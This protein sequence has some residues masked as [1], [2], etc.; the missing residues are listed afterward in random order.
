MA[1]SEKKQYSEMMSR[2][3]EKKRQYPDTIMFYRLGDF[4]EMFFDDAVKASEILG[5]TLT[6][7]DSGNKQKA[8]MCGIPYHAA[9]TYITRLTAAGYK[10]AIC[11]QIGPII[12][13]KIV[14]RDVVRIVTPG[15][16]MDES[17]LEQR[18]NNFI[19][20]VSAERESVVGL[21]W[22]DLTTGE[23]YLQQ[24]TGDDAFSRL[25]DMLV[26]I[27]PSEIIADELSFNESSKLACERM[28]VVPCFYQHKQSAFD[29][30][31]A[32][33][34]VL[35]QLKVHDLKEIN[36]ENI[37]QAVC[38]GGALLNYL[39]ETQMRDLTHINKVKVI[40]DKQY[41]HLDIN[42][43]LNL[44]LCE[45]LY[46]RKKKGS[47]L[48]VIDKTKSTMGARLLRSWLEQP[49]QDDI[50]IN[51]RLDA[52][53][54]L[55]NN[56]IARCELAE[57][58]RNF[59]DIERL[60]GRVSYGNLNP[61]NCVSLGQALV[62]L[63]R[64]KKLLNQFNSK[65][66]KECASKIA[67][68]ESL[69]KELVT[70]F[71]DNPPAILKDGGFI[72]KGFNPELDVYLSA[73]ENGN[74]WALDLEKKE[75][76][77][78]GESRLKVVHNRVIG[79]CFEI[80]KSGAENLPFRF[81]KIQTLTNVV[82]FMTNDLRKIIE[83]INN[84]EENKLNCELQIFNQIRQHILDKTR[85]IQVSA[86]QVARIDCLL[87]LA[88]V[89]LENDYHK[90]IIN[91]DIKDYEILQS[92]HPVVEK[93]MLNERFVPNDVI[94]N[95]NQRTI[96]ITGPNM[97]GK[98]T[99]MRQIALVVLLAHIGS[100]VPAQSAKIAMT[101]RIFTRIG[102][103]DNLGMGQSTFMVEMTEVANI[104]KNATSNSLLILD[105]IGRGTSTQDGLSIAW[106]VLEYIATTIK[107]RTLF[108]T[109]YHKLTEL[110]GKLPGVVNM[111]V[112]V[113]EFDNQ[114]SF[115]RKVEY[116]STNQSFGV[117]VAKLA[118]IPQSIINRAKE[119]M[120]DEELVQDKAFD[121]AVE[122]YSCEDLG[123]K[124]KYE[125][126]ADILNKTDVNNLT[127]L[128]ALSKIAELKKKIQ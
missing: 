104:I 8:P 82:R 98:S 94:F 40:D 66:I 4:Y 78:T 30:D 55:T 61:K 106:A 23:F 49:L 62:R 44:E 35:R 53:E 19:A 111:R 67:N 79:Y 17:Q 14:E 34:A 74:K 125:I 56:T 32:R 46:D 59:Q 57:L 68:L 83:D 41:M 18:K 22:I 103:S 63:P 117:E 123:I 100:F 92:R 96:I 20:C 69:A 10:V 47:L 84:A 38:A 37:L 128:E 109:H 107:A 73:K 31:T 115:L 90:P 33:K 120:K 122:Q 118:G 2:Y 64:I 39:Q 116:G 3:L 76:E 124:T 97:A 9:D 5:I 108:S 85:E 127:P 121:K 71:V 72:R 15:T 12:P 99:Y 86:Q 1:E 24:F 87:S 60:C 52:V 93:L 81:Q 91:K 88:E 75:R 102:A 45:T 50:E 6:S 27:I 110:E 113:S 54:E 70:A 101:D 126:I 105:E 29:Y 13:N 58:L 51:A 119:V 28:G 25:S 11:E 77:L 42:S 112:T 48:W 21:S 114:M 95:D 16:L 43:R 36:C 80:P 89:A 65:M 26:S 7:R